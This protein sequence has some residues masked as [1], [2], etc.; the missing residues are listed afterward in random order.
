MQKAL[1]NIICCYGCVDLKYGYYPFCLTN[2]IDYHALI[3]Q[4]VNYVIDVELPQQRRVNPAN[5]RKLKALLNVLSGLVPYEVDI[6]KLATVTGLQRNT[7]LEYL[8]HLKDAKLLFLLYSDLV[9]VKII[10]GVR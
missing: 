2:P 3:E 6:S 1:G 7:V 9:S 10:I 5:C 4:T 8:N